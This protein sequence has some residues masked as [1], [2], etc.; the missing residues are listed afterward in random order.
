MIRVFCK[1]SLHLKKLLVGYRNLFFIMQLNLLLN[2][3]NSLQL[4]IH[5]AHFFIIKLE[6]IIDLIIDFIISSRWV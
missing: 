5:L 2:E 6:F 1:Y 4:N 3:Q